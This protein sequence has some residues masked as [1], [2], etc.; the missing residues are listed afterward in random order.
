LGETFKRIG[1][2]LG[3]LRL[4]WKVKGVM[5]V[6]LKALIL[7]SAVVPTMFG[8]AFNEA[9]DKVAAELVRAECDVV[10]RTAKQFLDSRGLKVA[11]G[12]SGEDEDW[13]CGPGYR[14]IQFKNA[15]PRKAD[16]KAL[17]RGEVV[18]NY[19]K[20]PDKIDFRRKTLGHGYWATPNGNFVMSAKLQ[21][22]QEPAGCSAKL[23]MGFGLGGTVFLAVVPYDLYTWP[24][25]PDNGKLQNEYM[26]SI[27]RAMP[28]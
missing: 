17:T 22:K 21:L 28:Q 27:V 6:R 7:V 3:S 14:C 20:D 5:V 1:P 25:P 11:Q 9:S 15:R 16:G 26:A 18:K 24:I 8:Q 13:S 2:C 23:Q 4:F 10:A 19:L 12:Y